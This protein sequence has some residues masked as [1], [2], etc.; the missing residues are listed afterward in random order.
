MDIPDSVRDWLLDPENPSVRYFTLVDLLERPADDAQVMEARQEIMARGDVPALLEGQAEGGYW[1]HPSAFYTPRY[2][3]AVWRFM[4]LAE[5]GAD[6]A[7]PQIRKTAEHLF[8]Y[9]QMANGGFAAHPTAT[10]PPEYR[11]I[12]CLTG[13]MVWSYIRLGYLDD[14]RL[15]RGIDWIIKYSRF[16]D[17]DATAW[18]EWLPQDPNDG[19]W[20]RHTCFRGVIALLQALAAGV[21]FLLIHHV[22]KHS[23]NL[24]KPVT[25]Y[26]QV[27]FPMFVDNDLLRTLLFLTRMGIRDERMREAVDCLARKQ[28]KAGQWKQQHTYAKTRWTGFLPVPVAERGQPS[29]W[30]TLRALTV[31]KR[32]TAG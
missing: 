17:G 28:T 25:K 26:T 22:Y 11:G 4:L 7:H 21:E 20:G 14:P 23:H 16:D 9:A 8:E 3:G 15:Q 13:N 12:P 5:Y 19:C 27:G 31:L 6:G 24:S 10:R 29:K 32:Y 18:P 30:V 2:T 1:D